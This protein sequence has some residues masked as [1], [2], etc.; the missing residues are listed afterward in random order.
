M[1]NK[2][3]YNKNPY[4]GWIKTLMVLLIIA[5]GVSFLNFSNFKLLGKQENAKEYVSKEGTINVDINNITDNDDTSNEDYITYAD[6]AAVVEKYLNTQLKGQT[7]DNPD[8]KKAV[9]LTFDDGPSETVTPEILRILK[10]E[11][12]KATFFVVGKTIESSDKSK[13]LLK[14]E[15]K[16]G[17]SIGNHTYSHNYDYLYPNRSV[18]ATNF[19]EEIDK[20]NTIIK[21]VLGED[22][23]TN[24]I[25]FPGGHM[26]W[27]N[28]SE[29]DSI[30]Q[31][32]NYHYIDWN[33][34][35]KDAEG[36]KKNAS[37][38]FEEVKKSAGEKMRVVVLMHDTYGKEETAKALPDIIKYFKAKGYEFRTIQ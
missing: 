35:S 16:E 33:S 5:I 8:N 32:E 14:Q 7:P 20:T 3:L 28:T 17:H 13:S 21:S 38:L 36:A 37:E 24:I 29:V 27:K 22:F 23:K 30:M 4:R 1:K 12:V 10:E 18:N 9:Y 26:S 25:R 34:L 11:D 31:S 19:M 2:K 6:D 15:L